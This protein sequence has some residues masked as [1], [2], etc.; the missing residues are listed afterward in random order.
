MLH[1][2]LSVCLSVSAMINY[3]GHVHSLELYDR[4]LVVVTVVSKMRGSKSRLGDDESGKRAC[5]ANNRRPYTEKLRNCCGNFS[6]ARKSWCIEVKR[7][8]GMW[9]HDMVFSAN[10]VT[11]GLVTRTLGPSN[12]FTLLNGCTGKCVRLSRLLAFECTLNHFLSFFLSMLY[13]NEQI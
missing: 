8:Q 1:S 12:D 13:H 9:S 5:S 2:R 10:I 11:T 4:G 3:H 6:A 7:S